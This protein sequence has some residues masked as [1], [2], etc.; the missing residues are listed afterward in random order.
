MTDE[1]TTDGAVDQ[2]TPATDVN[3]QGTVTPDPNLDGDTTVAGEETPDG[4]GTQGDE[5]AEYA[6]FEM[7]EGMEVNAEQLNSYIPVFKEMKLTQEQAQKLVSFRAKEVQAEEKAR[8]EAHTQQGIEWEKEARSDKEI[9]GDKFDENLAHAK[10]A[11]DTYFAPEFKALL[12]DSKLGNHPEF[13]RG[14]Y[15]MGLTL[16]E[17]NPGAGG[18]PPTSKKTIT[19]LLYPDAK[20]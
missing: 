20:S 1:N 19:D 18:Q 8:I 5:G 16:R 2:Q 6:D 15:K 13:I 17:D 7:P 10:K 11:L 4:D 9:G 14:L 3:D 12:N